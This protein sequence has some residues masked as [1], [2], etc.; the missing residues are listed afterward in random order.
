MSRE[1]NTPGKTA[2]GV[3]ICDDDASVRK[4]LRAVVEMRPSFRVVGEAADGDEAIVEAARAQPDVILLDLA[5]PRRTGLDA[6]PELGRV[7]P[8]AKIIVLTGFSEASVAQDVIDLGAVRFLTKGASPD[9]IND[10][11]EEAA[12]EAA[13]DRSRDTYYPLGHLQHGRAGGPH[14]HPSHASVVLAWPAMTDPVSW[15]QIEQGWNV[16][17]AN[18][19][20][21]GTV[22]QVEGDKQSDIFDGLAVESVLSGGI[23]YVPGEQVG[24]IHPG[25]VTLKIDSAEAGRL[26]PF[27]APPLETTWH[28]GKPPLSARISGWLHGKR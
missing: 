20:A 5:M 12:A 17:A 3:L 22:A 8:A 19:A 11:I 23:R 1:A 4:L 6:I 13:T 9:A 25:E 27:Q 16:V 14:R 15:L 26:E 7:A 21:V 24:A 18:G 28:P 10:A 2:V